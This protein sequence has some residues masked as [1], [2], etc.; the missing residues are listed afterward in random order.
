MR[1]GIFPNTPCCANAE[2]YQLDGM[3]IPEYAKGSISTLE[4]YRE[5]FSSSPG[6]SPGCRLAGRVHGRWWQRRCRTSSGASAASS[7]GGCSGWQAC[8][9]SA[10]VPPSPPPATA[11]PAP[12]SVTPPP[13]FLHQTSALQQCCFL[14]ESQHGLPR[15]T[16][17]LVPAMHQIKTLC[18]ICR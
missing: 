17:T 7:A 10:R 14:G 18:L 15:K 11:P 2:L 1:A 6:L 16:L 4:H 5:L 12:G 13:P 8:G 9:S 3:R